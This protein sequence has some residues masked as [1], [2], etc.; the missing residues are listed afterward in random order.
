MKR[1]KVVHLTSAHGPFDGRI[2]CKESKSLAQ[3]GYEV[4]VI[5]PHSKDEFVDG[6]QIKAVAKPKGRLSRIIL[7]V[8]HVYREAAR[9]QE[10]VYH[11]HE[12]ELIPVGLLLRARG[13]KVVY[14]IH[15]DV[16]STILHKNYLPQWTRQSSA[17]VIR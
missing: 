5:A 6:V 17:R 16:P 10:D 14:D 11:F 4:T 3:A 2:F 12:P 8:W 1:V 13:K 15:E 9:K 7:T